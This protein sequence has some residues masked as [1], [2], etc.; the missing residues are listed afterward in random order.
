MH[1][2]SLTEELIVLIFTSKKLF[3]LIIVIKK[4]FLYV[5]VGGV[6]GGGVKSRVLIVLVHT[7]DWRALLVFGF[8]GVLRR[9]LIVHRK[10]TGLL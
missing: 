9:E 5:C 2:K 4:H 10:Q 6:G 3:T 1:V 8:G 7:C